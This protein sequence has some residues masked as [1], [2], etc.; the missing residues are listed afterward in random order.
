MVII[1]NN[2][3]IVFVAGVET[4]D[5]GRGLPLW[6]GVLAGSLAGLILLLIIIIIVIIIIKRRRRRKKWVSVYAIR[7]ANTY[8]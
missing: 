8:L 2:K 1:V 6:A 4:A 5:G 3:W 7:Y